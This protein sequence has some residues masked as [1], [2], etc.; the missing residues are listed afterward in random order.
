MSLNI[1]TSD[2]NGDVARAAYRARLRAAALERLARAGRP[3]LREQAA[4]SLVALAARLA[5]TLRITVASGARQIA[6]LGN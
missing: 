2:P 6:T 1:Y 4:R 3:A 5:P